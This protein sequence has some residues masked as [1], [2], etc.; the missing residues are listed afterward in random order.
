MKNK[1]RVIFQSVIMGMILYVAIRPVFDANYRPDFEAYCPFGGLSSLF[2]KLNLGTM[3]CSMGEV[4]VMMGIGL[5]VAVVLFG[6]LFCSYICPIG[7]VTEWLGKLGDKLK[8]RRDIPKVLD[9]P[10]RVLKY[11]LLFI[12]VYFT[13]TS[14]ELFCKTFDPYFAVVNLFGNPD[15]NLAYAIIAFTITIVGSI[16]F[17]FFW[18]KY[19]CPLG[20]LSNIFYNA[21]PVAGAIVLYII[22]NALGAELS[23]VWLFGAMVVIGL[24]SEVGFMRS[25]VMPGVRIQRNPDKCT[26]CGLCAK[27]C[28]QG[29]KITDF[30]E[31]NHIDCNLCS[32]CVY[33]CKVDGALTISKKKMPKYFAPVATAVVIALSLGFASQ[34]EFTTISERWGG[35]ENVKEVGVYRHEGLKTVKCFGSARSL[36]QQLGRIK[37]IVGMDAY[38]AS[39][40][41]E[42]FYDKNQIKLEDVKE[43][44]FVPTKQMCRNLA[45]DGPDSLNVWEVGIDGVFDRVD[46]TNLVRALRVEEG[47]YGFQ[48]MFGEP[49]EALVYYDAAIID[50]N[51]IKE[52]VEAEEISY[53]SKG[54]VKTVEIEFSISEHGKSAGKIGNFDFRKLMF[55]SFSSKV[56]KYDTHDTKNVSVLVYPKEDAWHPFVKRKMPYLVSHLSDNNGIIRFA[57]GYEQ[58]GPMCLVY[59]DTTITNIDEVRKILTAEKMNVHYTNGTTKQMENSFK[60]VPEG[61]IVKFD[62]LAEEYK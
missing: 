24:I 32:D 57:T 16:V 35:F 60:D 4:Q 40:T 34:F 53:N 59:F 31:V 9:R 54:A 51:K 22:A 17:R 18:C 3:S 6:K 45:P 2:S 26:N 52:L 62:N 8:I 39:H 42:I 44:I 29:I 25:F 43:S 28:P 61:K 36:A 12:T 13:M 20:A 23:L 58:D 15:M 5:L 38:A 14:S 19:L 50:T 56:N 47:V 46:Y 49:I 48:T 10:L 30:E 55:H 1:L 21:I 7:T 41:I 27:K 37:G 33:T 11:V